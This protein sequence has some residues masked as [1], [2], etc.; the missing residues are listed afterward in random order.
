MFIFHYVCIPHNSLPNK[1]QLVCLYVV[2]LFYPM[3]I[4]NKSELNDILWKLSG[5]KVD[6]GF[7]SGGAV[8]H[9]KASQHRR[10]L[11]I[12]HFTSNKYSFACYIHLCVISMGQ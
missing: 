6:P 8:W 1:N 10:C 5:F 4:R 11:E 2:V 3:S 9:V 7:H 12:I